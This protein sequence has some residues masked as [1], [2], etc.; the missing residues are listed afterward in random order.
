MLARLTSVISH[1]SRVNM[2]T[3]AGTIHNTNKACCSIPPVQSSYSPRGTTTS[4]GGF[5]KVYVTGPDQSE[6]GIV[7]VYDIFG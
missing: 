6:N 5:D 3:T 7:V 2:S 1:L 4:Y